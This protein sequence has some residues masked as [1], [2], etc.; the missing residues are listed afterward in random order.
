[1]NELTF[2]YTHNDSIGYGRMGVM[3]HEAL[4][5]Q[6]VAVYDDLGD[7]PPD[8]DN[9]TE[10]SER[11]GRSHKLTNVVC[12]ASVPSH[13]RWWY[14]GQFTSAFTMW[15]A[16]VLPYSF[17]ESMHEFDLLIVPSQQNVEL[18]SKYH[19]NVRLNELGVDP[20]RW[21]YVPRTPP[22]QFFDFLIGG[23][24]LRK[25]TDLAYKAFNEVFGKFKGKGPIPRLL[26]KNPKGESRF[27][28]RDRVVMTS[29]KISNEAEVALYA[30][31]HCYLQ[32]SRG[33]GFGLQPLQ[34][35]AQGLPT[36]LTDAHGHGSFAKYGIPLGWSW[37]KADYFIY[38]D[39]GDWWEPD[40]DQLCE[41]MWDVYHNWQPHV[42]A[43]EQVA[44]NVIPKYFT[45]D[46][47]ADRFI[48]AHDGALE[49]PYTGD[50]SYYYPEQL[51]YLV[52]VT[53]PFSADIAGAMYHWR[54]TDDEGNPKDY[55]EP[56]D[57][58]RILFEKGSL[59][60]VCLEGDDTGLAEFQIARIGA[61][62][63]AQEWCPTCHQQLNT[64]VQ[65][66]DVILS[67][68]MAEAS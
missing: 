15:E 20:E 27:R 62:T 52:R 28:G 23:S 57:V 66:A 25:G 14:T 7:P 35:M 39:A 48:D 56:A 38:G 34:A 16:S 26:M 3:L 53:A 29:G 10:A 19:D 31:A 45:W 67:E 63:A 50:K 5:R 4:A 8:R 9:H 58:K 65:K 33:E 68:M 60:P 55:Y 13:A 46:H 6:G 22:D 59:D 61:H 51:R 42:D 44:K 1:M 2:L 64:G 17:R 47:C 36:I 41:S 24:G 21:H 54:P 18:F 43:A 49:R 11:V 30:S 32:P 37:K 40:Y 12:W